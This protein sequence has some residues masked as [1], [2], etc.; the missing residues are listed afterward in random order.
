VGGKFWFAISKNDSGT[1]LDKL[2]SKTGNN[3]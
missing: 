1:L 2:T 3:I